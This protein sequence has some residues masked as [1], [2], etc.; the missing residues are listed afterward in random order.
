MP[1]RRLLTYLTLVLISTAITL[2]LAELA[3]RI[4]YPQSLGVWYHTKDGMVIHWPNLKRQHAISLQEIRINSLGMRDREH[5]VAKEKGVLRILVLGDSFMEA[6]QV[7]FEESFPRLLE[8]RLQEALHQTVEVINAAVSGWGSDDQLT[9]LKRYGIKFKPDLILVGMTLHNDV[10]D[11]MREKFHTIVGDKLVARP[12]QNTPFVE[13]VIGRSKD[14]I[15]VNSHLYQLFREYR[16]LRDMRNGGERLNKHVV[17]LISKVDTAKLRKGWE[18]TYQLLKNIQIIGKEIDAKTGIFLIPLSLQL[19]EG[20]LDY[21]LARHD[22]SRDEICLYKPQKMMKEFGRKEGIEIIDLVPYFTKW[23]EA[24]QKELY[25]RG[26]GHWNQYGHRV[27][28]ESIVQKLLLSGL[29][30]H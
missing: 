27:A 14:F 23:K 29:I 3:L 9:Y 25:L 7:S 1:V 30:K 4:F 10:S 18:L 2:V 17:D 21:F 5:P 13:Y 26:D 8:V 6:F 19:S 24:N 20:T 28:S 12:V 22:V 16:H 11:N 15:A